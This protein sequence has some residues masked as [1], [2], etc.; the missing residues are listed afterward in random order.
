[1]DAFAEETASRRRVP[2][3]LKSCLLRALVLALIAGAGIGLVAWHL[4]DQFE[5]DPRLQAVVLAA[6]ESPRGRAEL[7][8]QFAVMQVD[9]RFFPDKGGKGEDFRLVVIGSKGQRVLNAR[10]EPVHGGMKI[11]R[12]TLSPRYGG[13]DIVLSGSTP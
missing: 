4:Y 9:R 7:G 10:L 13:R 3:W 1:M 8:S 12:L 11:T 5:G 6:K 2:G